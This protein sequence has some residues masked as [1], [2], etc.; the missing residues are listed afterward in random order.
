MSGRRPIFAVQNINTPNTLW[1]NIM[2]SIE[3]RRLMKL[4]ESPVDDTS[5]RMADFN[6]TVRHLSKSFPEVIRNQ[7]NS[8][9]SIF[10]IYPGLTYYFEEEDDYEALGEERL[11]P[12]FQ[13]LTKFLVSLENAIKASLTKSD[14]FITT[15]FKDE[16]K[17]R[18]AYD[19]LREVQ[20]KVGDETHLIKFRTADGEYPTTNM[21]AIFV[22][23]DTTGEK[24]SD[25]SDP[26]MI[27]L[28][29]WNLIV[30]RFGFY[31][32]ATGVYHA[33]PGTVK[34]V[35]VHVEIDDDLIADMMR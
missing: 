5:T 21:T 2:N 26:E 14:S 15:R 29:A 19:K 35:P 27:L 25:P 11:E 23:S 34:L 3:M 17:V 24:L 16:A 13:N 22:D 32:I 20:F 18:A 31:S 30:D 12:V 9:S 6:K 10:D 8:N 4:V 33:M 28:D 1:V 7:I